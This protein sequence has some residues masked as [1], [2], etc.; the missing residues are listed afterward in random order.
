MLLAR[1]YGLPNHV[2]GGGDVD[3]DGVRDV[4]EIRLGTNPYDAVIVLFVPLN[5]LW[6]AIGVLVGCVLFLRGYFR[7]NRS[8]SADARRTS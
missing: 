1:K 4:D 8:R 6:M 7:G 3:D 2:E 5:A